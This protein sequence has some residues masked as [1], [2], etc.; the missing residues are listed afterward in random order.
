MQAFDLD[1][2]DLVLVEHHQGIRLL[3]GA[4]GAVPHQ[5]G[6]ILVD[7]PETVLGFAP[8]HL[9]DVPEGVHVLFV[10]SAWRWGVGGLDRGPGEGRLSL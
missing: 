1:V 2:E 5:E 10:A 8:C 3:H 6:T 7:L 9:A 4:F